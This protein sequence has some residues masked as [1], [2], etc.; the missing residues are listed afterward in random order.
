M[1]LAI[2]TLAP[3][4]NYGGIAQAWALRHILMEMGHQATVVSLALKP[5]TALRYGI[6]NILIRNGLHPT[7]HY[8]IPS[9]S[10][11]LSITAR[12][13]P[14]IA[15]QIAPAPPCSPRAL[16]TA[17]FD[18]YIV[19]SDQVWSPEYTRPYGAENFFLAFLPPTDRRLRVAYGAS[20][21][22]DKWRFSESESNALRILAQRFDA[23]SV[24][25]SSAVEI[26]RNHLGV[27]CTPV[28]DPVM[29]VGREK[30]LG[31]VGME[32]IP[33]RQTTFCYI[34]D[35]SEQKQS[36]CQLI[37]DHRSNKIERFLP[38]SP[39]EVLPSMEE[40]IAGFAGAGC[41]VTD[42]F[43]G[44][45][46]ALLMERP[47]VVLGN[48]ERGMARFGSLLGA[49][50]LESRLIAPDCPAPEAVMEMPIEWGKVRERIG[51]M[52]RSS[53]QFLSNA[54]QTKQ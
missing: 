10:E 45:V 8:H 24:R 32:P 47:F 6:G 54:L 1:R 33:Q 49:L 16:S 35:P 31:I 29:V 23:L 14:F 38:D 15:E 41:V 22:S 50:N 27:E 43:H 53:L 52:R 36:I 25:E 26:C 44:M 34:L 51:M 19:G 20:M 7:K 39:T 18:G 12:L 48:Q 5:L 4:T 3:A 28:A 42:S 40:W 17:K 13:R 30:L 2:L 46:M 9:R 21:G 11:Q 37:A